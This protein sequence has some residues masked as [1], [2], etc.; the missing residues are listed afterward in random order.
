MAGRLLSD[1]LWEFKAGGEGQLADPGNGNTI[2]ITRW[3]QVCSVATGGAE[4]ITLAQPDKQGIMG[5]VVLETDG[6]DLTLTVTGGYNQAAD[7]AIVFDT[8]G[9][10]IVFYSIDV[11]GVFL[12]RIWNQ[13][14]TDASVET[15]T[16][17]SA[18]LRGDTFIAQDAPTAEATGAQTIDA[19]DF[20]NG[21]VVHTVAAASTLTTPT[22][23]Q[24]AAVLPAGV[25]TGDSFRLHVITIGAGADDISTLTAGDANVTFVGNVTVGPD[26]GTTATNGF[27]T[28]IFRMT[29]AD[30]F[31]GYRIG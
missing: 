11:G 2:T 24:I 20:V 19:A 12:W 1:M 3:G 22:G 13:S 14:G 30:T 4:A 8:A 21:I 9:D 15:L 28:W 16:T 5:A 7:T 10:F 6:G 23:A 31:V 29:G 25:T 18:I 27:G 17:K 26:D